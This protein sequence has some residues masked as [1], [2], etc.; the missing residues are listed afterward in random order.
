[1]LNLIYV[2]TTDHMVSM[3]WLGT[4]NLILDSAA[5]V[6]VHAC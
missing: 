1:M 2:L 5:P 6:L 3:N 4:G